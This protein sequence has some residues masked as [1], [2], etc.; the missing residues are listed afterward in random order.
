MKNTNLKLNKTKLIARLMIVILLLTSTL[1]LVSCGE[2]NIF[3]FYDHQC[4]DEYYSHEEFQRFIEKYNSKNDGF[5]GTFISFDFDSSSKVE[6]RCYKWFMVAK[7]NKYMGDMI[8]DKYQDDNLGLQFV[9]Y[10]NDVDE[11]GTTIK[12][13]YQ[14]ICSG[15]VGHNKYNFYSKDVLSLTNVGN[16]EN[17]LEYY[18][19]SYKFDFYNPLE[20]D[21]EYI[22]TYDLCVNENHYMNIIVAALEDTV[23]EEKLD[24]ICKLLMDNI[25]IINTE[26]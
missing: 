2:A 5:V 1:T 25:V 3:G 9:L 13:A 19:N 23:P 18:Y 7:L 12:N 17:S 14:I 26:G 11:N 22:T 6:E 4:S 20:L 24:E 8:F 15:I 21:Y 10:I 16:G